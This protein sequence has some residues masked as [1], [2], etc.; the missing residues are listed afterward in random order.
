MGLFGFKANFAAFYDRGEGTALTAPPAP[1]KMPLTTFPFF[2]GFTVDFALKV[3]QWSE[4]ETVRLQLWDIA[5]MFI[6]SPE[7]HPGWDEAPPG[8]TVL[9]SLC[10][11]GRAF[12]MQSRSGCRVVGFP[13]PVFA[14]WV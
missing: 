13:P 9:S 6:Q 12:W 8:D 10:W 2:W 7:L 1:C 3:V 4:S 11:D 14:V 5:G